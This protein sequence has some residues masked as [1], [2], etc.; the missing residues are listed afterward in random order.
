MES[1][2]ATSSSK[3]AAGGKLKLCCSVRIKPC[4][5]APPGID[6]YDGTKL[7]VGGTVLGPFTSII[8]PNEGQASAYDQV[9][10]PLV[11]SFRQGINCTVFMYG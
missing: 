4:G 10:G 2:K 5:S 8:G 7:Q 11:D 9:M 1:K 6:G 3:G